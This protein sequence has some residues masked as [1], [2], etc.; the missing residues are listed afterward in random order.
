[1]ARAEQETL[2]FQ[3]ISW[4]AEDVADESGEDGSNNYVIKVFGMDPA[5]DSVSVTITGFTPFFYIKTDESWDQNKMRAFGYYTS[6]M[7]QS[8]KPRLVEIE[9]K[10]FW[11]FSNMKN[12]KFIKL[13]FSSQEDMRKAA[14]CLTRHKKIVPKVSDGEIYKYLLYESNIDP[15]L[16]FMHIQN[17][18]PS[19]WIQIKKYSKDTGILNTHCKRD[20]ETSHSNIKPFKSDNTAAF[21]VASFDIEC[22]ST[23][24]EFPVP[25]KDYKMVCTQ[26]YDV[27]W[28]MD[29]AGA[30]V[31]KKRAAILTCILEAFDLEVEEN[32]TSPKH[33]EDGSKQVVTYHPSISRVEPK[34]P[35]DETVFTEYLNTLIIDDLITIIQSKSTTATAITPAKI[36]EAAITTMTKFLNHGKLMPKLSGD[37]IIQIG[38]TFHRYGQTECFAR[39]VVTLGTCAKH[40]VPDTTVVTCRTESDVLIAWRQMM[41]K[42]D[43][44]I[45]T[46]YNIFGFDFE[47][48]VKRSVELGIKK[49]FM[50]LS[51]F[52]GRECSYVENR[53]QSSALGDNLLKYIP[54]E[55]RVMVDLMKVVMRDHKL[56]SYKLDDVA[57]HFTGQNKHAVSPQEIFELQDGS[58]ED[59]AKIAAYCVQDCALCNYLVMKLEIVANNM[60][61]SN[62]CLV[63]MEFIFMRGQGIKIFSLVLSEC[64]K[65]NYLI[66]VLKKDISVRKEDIVHFAGESRS[67]AIEDTTKLMSKALR[68]NV[69]VEML[70]PSAIIAGLMHLA[71][72]KHGLDVPYEAIAKKYA[73]LTRSEFDDV[74]LKITTKPQRGDD[75]SD[76]DEAR[77]RAQALQ[78]DG[79]EGAIVLEPKVGIYI[80]DPISVLD[81]AS[82]YPSSMI[83]ENLSHDCMVLDAQYD[84][85][86]GIEYLDITYDIFDDKKT[87]VGDQ[88]C[89]FVQSHVGVIPKILKKLLTARKTTR[90]K[91]TY[92]TGQQLATTATTS[93]DLALVSGIYDESTHTIETASGETFTV[94]PESVKPAYNAFQIAVLDGLQNAYKV[95]A[96]SLYGQIGAKTSQ[97]YLKE[98]AACTTATGRKMITMAKEFLET[99][100][101]A[102]VIYGDTDSIFVRFPSNF[103]GHDKIMPSIH[104]AKAASSEFRKTIKSPH[105]LEYE[106]TYWPFLLLG[107]KK[108][109]GNE[110]QQNDKKKKLKT[111]GVVMK[112]RDNAPIVKKIY[113]GVLDIILNQ[114]DV[115]AS[116]TFTLDCL[117]QLVKGNSPLDE[118][119]ITKSLKSDYKDPTK[120]AH[121]V[122]A[123]RIA[124]RSPGDRPQSNDRI[125]YVYVVHAPAAKGEKV[126]QGEKIETPTFIKT[127]NLTVDY[128]FYITNQIM[129]PLLQLFA[130]VLEQ[131]PGYNRA[132]NFFEKVRADMLVDNKGDEELT[133][134]KMQKLREVLVKQLLF[135]PIL[136][137]I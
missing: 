55:G 131:L 51:R 68:T 75:E 130:L 96:N 16:R 47:Y 136:K 84:N 38:T 116:V 108:Y 83:S 127:N 50:K 46:G 112:R 73:Y 11:G 57:H 60:G 119:V 122:L 137:K 27:Y 98:I 104:Q 26:L 42:A 74:I 52:K 89:R 134:D 45:V 121:K 94:A 109:V 70:K 101:E 79:Y 76:S 102:E 118:L 93:E 62:V 85:L 39:H 6:N 125:P 126:L 66:P 71:C 97:I 63:P 124:E 44:D 91:M 59:R 135:D 133:S 22:T 90:K 12:F 105:D 58:A 7:L 87:K 35:F 110:Y 92:V 88:R 25:V 14:A 54:M 34:A 107:K 49:Q 129:N 115:A 56:D 32:R 81:Y 77:A 65:E 17:I 24:G 69:A 95:T 114:Q 128:G 72:K 20:V 3:A 5:G 113:G 106:K 103:Q 30:S 40:L 117:G 82:L 21:I 28:T 10:D 1:M 53:L 41:E 61:M 19:G 120:I 8:Y 132:P 43:P 31:Y 64:R 100:C 67:V 29:K 36:R 33:S 48:M 9:A 23:G 99:S 80:K 123:D 78:E 2:V 15:Y 37:R 86:P 4:H 18:E 111:M 13:S